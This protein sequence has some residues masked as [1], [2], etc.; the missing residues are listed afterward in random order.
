MEARGREKSRKSAGNFSPLSSR[1]IQTDHSKICM[2][3]MYFPCQLP[4]TC[5]EMHACMDASFMSGLS[6]LVFIPQKYF[7][8]SIYAR[9]MTFIM[10]LTYAA[11]NVHNFAKKK[12]CTTSNKMQ[13]CFAQKFYFYPCSESNLTEKNIHWT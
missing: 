13:K 9:D 5:D 12:N 4:G 8:Q 3:C 6:S 2:Q 7:R 10:L 1:N 11:C